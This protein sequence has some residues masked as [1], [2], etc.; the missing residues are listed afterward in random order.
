MKI[1]DLGEGAEIYDKK[2]FDPN[3]P[4]VLIDGYGRLLLSQIKQKIKD[5]LLIMSEDTIDNIDYELK[6]GTL[7]VLVDAVKDVER[8][9]NSPQMKRK[10]TLRARQ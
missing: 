3:D 10:A 1:E 8:E 5:K 9:M 7:Q 4:E 6:N 2:D